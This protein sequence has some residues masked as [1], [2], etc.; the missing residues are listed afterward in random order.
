[1]VIFA[2]ISIYKGLVHKWQKKPKIITNDEIIAYITQKNTKIPTS[3]HHFDHLLMNFSNL[4][5]SF[6][7]NI[8]H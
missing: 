6:S 7:D 8:Y 2:F 5:L 4:K 1:M 3:N